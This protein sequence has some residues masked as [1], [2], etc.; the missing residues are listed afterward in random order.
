MGFIDEFK[1]LTQPYD[2]DEDFFEGSEKPVFKAPAPAPAPVSTAED[3]DDETDDAQ[4]EFESSFRVGSMGRE[5]SARKTAEAPAQENGGGL[6]GNLGVRKPR[7]V[8][9]ERLVSFGGTESQVILFSPKGFD[10][11][12]ELVAYLQQHRSVVMTLEGLP[13]EQARRMLDLCS[14]VALALSGKITPVSGKTYFVTPVNVDIVGS[15][16]SPVESDG[17]YF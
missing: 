4:A 3:E 2:E 16:P 11:A 17:Q 1:K 6:F 14:G 12:K 8:Q 13:N 10:D 7:P 15:Q 5:L 9:R